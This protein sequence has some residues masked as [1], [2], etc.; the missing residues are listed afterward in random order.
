MT[1]D[2]GAWRG[3]RVLVT[4][5]GGFIGRHLVARLER[6]GADVVG[7]TRQACEL[8]DREA[9]TA[10]VRAAAPDVV[11]HLAAARRKAS[12]GERTDTATVNAVSG[13]WLVEALPETC[14]AVVR[15]GSST[16]YA[17]SPRPMDEDTPL[18]P[19]GFQ[20]SSVAA[21]E[22]SATQ[23]PVSHERPGWAPDR[24]AIRRPVT[25]SASAT[26]SSLAVCTPVPMLTT[27]PLARSSRSAA[28]RH[29]STTSSTATQSRRRPGAVSGS[30]VP[31][32]AARSTVGT[33]RSGW[34]P[35]P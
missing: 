35:G 24:V 21:A 14:R 33:K 27:A 28:S 9:V 32:A 30:S 16:E 29:A 34:S 3:Q 6:D 2:P 10:A 23:S 22:G 19:R 8:T 7:L 31:V 5:A 13:L 18:R 26:S 11:M 12:G 4:G 17:A 1:G 20:D 15:L 25:R